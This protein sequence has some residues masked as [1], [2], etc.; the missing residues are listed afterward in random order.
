MPAPCGPAYTDASGANAAASHG[1]DATAA[2][3]KIDLNAHNVAVVPAHGFYV[4]SANRH[5]QT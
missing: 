3:I 5:A 1:C 2:A 4:F